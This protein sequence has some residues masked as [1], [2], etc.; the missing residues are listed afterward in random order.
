MQ[1]KD[2]SCKFGN[3]FDKLKSS[4]DNLLAEGREQKLKRKLAQK[5][6]DSI[7][8]E[9]IE[10]K[11]NESDISGLVD[12]DDEIVKLFSCIFPIF[13][14]KGDIIFRLYKHKI[15]VNLSDEMSDRYI[16]IFSDGRFT[17]G[18]FECY[19]LGTDEYL[20]GVKKIIEVIPEFRTAIIRE[21]DS[22]KKNLEINKQTVKTSIIREEQ[23][24]KNY[25]DL[26]KM[27]IN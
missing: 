19:N 25:N 2:N 10:T 14:K 16:Y 13:I 27:L 18:N 5:I 11:L 6:K 15:E 3:S 20:Y 21:L 8:N 9:E 26:N 23:A 1:S 12:E 22:F 4:I 24:E 17:A 7:F